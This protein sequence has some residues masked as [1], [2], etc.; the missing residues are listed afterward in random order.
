M[1]RPEIIRIIQRDKRSDDDLIAWNN[2]YMC[3]EMV[4]H[5]YIIRQENDR[6]NKSFVDEAQQI[7]DDSDWR[8]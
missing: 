8:F 6:I 2:G 4:L 5:R 1:D 3:Y 7:I